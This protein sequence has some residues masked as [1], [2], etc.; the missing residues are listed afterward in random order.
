MKKISYRAKLFFSIISFAIFVA[1]MF[2]YGYSLMEASNTSAL[3]EVNKQNLELEVLKKEQ[4]NFEQGKMDLTT[5]DTKAYPPQ[6]LFSKDTKVVKEIQVLEDLAN[7]Y[8]LELNLSIAGTAS[9]AS[10]VNGVGSD[11]V[12]I[13]VTITIEGAFK[14]ILSFIDASEHTNFVLHTT[15]IQISAAGKVGSRV[16][17]NSQLYLKQ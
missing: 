15:A 9:S 12:T 17:L 11:L 2:S 13:P 4:K 7:R 14:N 3:D 16:T 10:K 1:L 5:L 6:D 8:E